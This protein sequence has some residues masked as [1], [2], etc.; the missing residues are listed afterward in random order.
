M[1]G[2]ETVR[3]KKQEQSV[4]RAGGEWKQK[5]TLGTSLVL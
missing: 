5:I 1:T 2:E 4:T 3:T